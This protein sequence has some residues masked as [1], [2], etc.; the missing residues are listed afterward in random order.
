[1]RFEDCDYSVFAS[2]CPRER[3]GIL[4]K[5]SVG[6]K[7]K[8]N[9]GTKRFAHEMHRIS[10]RTECVAAV[11]VAR[12]RQQ[13][14]LRA[15]SARQLNSDMMLPFRVLIEQDEDGRFA[16]GCLILPGGIAEEKNISKSVG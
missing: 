15:S 9:K 12:A 1:M 16:V 4:H 6:G 10:T 8:L 5:G 13:I 7:R 14:A 11:R 3:G 2:G